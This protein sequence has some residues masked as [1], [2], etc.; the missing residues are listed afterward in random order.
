MAAPDM[1]FGS[2]TIKIG[3]TASPSDSYEC[4]ITA[5]YVEPSGNV[6]TV[7]ATYC[8]GPTQYAQKSTY[9]L[10][11]EWIADF[12]ATNSLSDLLWDN[13]GEE[14]HIEFTPSDV[15]RPVLTGIFYAQA[16][17]FGGEGDGLWTSSNNMPMKG[18]PTRTPQEPPLAAKSAKS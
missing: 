7:P 12:G 4:Q 17:T 6:Q 18:Q 8:Q 5:C 2:G 3:A 15:T 9:S 1:I 16:G 11:M 10:R 13:D 14:M